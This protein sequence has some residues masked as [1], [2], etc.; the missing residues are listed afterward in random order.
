MPENE[1]L[2]TLWSEES[3]SYIRESITPP[4]TCRPRELLFEPLHL[5]YDY[6]LLGA[7]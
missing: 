5:K 2:L 7:L 3:E 1:S 4:G 6:Q